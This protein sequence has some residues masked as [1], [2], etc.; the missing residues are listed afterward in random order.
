MVK[1]IKNFKDL[2]TETKGTVKLHVITG[3]GFIRFTAKHDGDKLHQG[4]VL[5]AVCG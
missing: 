5:G 4:P 3:E 1:L 2:I